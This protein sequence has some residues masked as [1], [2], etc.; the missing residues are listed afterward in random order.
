LWSNL[1]DAVEAVV[2]AHRA[3]L[4]EPEPVEPTDEPIPVQSLQ[5]SPE[6][7]LAI[8]TRERYAAVQ[9]L[10]RR[11][12]SRAGIARELQLDAHTVRRFANATS[13]D[14]LLVKDHARHD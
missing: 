1:G 11:G 13:V 10:L 8:R 3:D 5:P 9:D 6:T 4:V 7:G 2:I 14:E 12:V